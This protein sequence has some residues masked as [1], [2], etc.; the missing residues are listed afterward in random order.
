MEKIH[1]IK[2]YKII[3]IGNIIGILFI[4]VELIFSNYH[5]FTHEIHE[6]LIRIMVFGMSFTLSAVFQYYNL[7]QGKYQQKLKKQNEEMKEVNQLK[8]EF[9]RRASHELKTPLIAIKGFSNLLMDLHQENL[10][11]D[12]LSMLGEIENGCRRF[13]SII[14]KILESSKLE[15]SK[16]KLQTS[17]EDLSFL[18]KFCLNELHSYFKSRNHKI[19]VKIED[20]IMIQFDKEQIY[21]VISNLLSN[22]IKYTSPN[23]EINIQTEI[24]DQAVIVK[25]QDTGIGF[26]EIEKK[27]A[28][29]QFGKIER[30]GQGFDLESEG[31][32]LGLYISKKIVESHGGKIWLESSGRERGSTFYFSLPIS[33]EKK[34]LMLQMV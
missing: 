8:S 9:L 31:S 24:K 13:E 19:N 26:T 11:D 10:N 16:V 28:F 3:I 15:S 20:T 7:K 21:E 23:G 12:I 33:K 34:K 30:Y 6:F 5:I 1:V 25:I 4:I 32:G 2:K 18:I 14:S 29:Q 17:M 27:R 22:A